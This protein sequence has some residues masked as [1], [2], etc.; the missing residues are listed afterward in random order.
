MAN[1]SISTSGV[2]E[3][4]LGG[5]AVLNINA[6]VGGALEDVD[7][8]RVVLKDNNDA[9]L[10]DETFTGSPI[11]TVATDGG[12][13]T[14]TDPTGTGNYR[15]S[16]AVPNDGTYT[17]TANGLQF[18]LEVTIDEGGDLGTNSV[19]FLV[20]PADVTIS[21]DTA[22]VSAIVKRRTGLLEDV[23]IPGE[24]RASDGLTLPLR[25]GITYE[26][27]A[28]YKNGSTI[29]GG[30]TDYTWFTFSPNVLLTAAATDDDF[31]VF[32]VQTRMQPETITDFINESQDFI[33]AKLSPFYDISGLLTH[34]TVMSLVAARTIG[35]IKEELQEGVALENA[36][37]RS[38]RELIDETT[39][40]VKAICSG[41]VGLIGDDGAAVSRRD[42]AI[43]GGFIHADGDVSARIDMVDRAQKWTG[44]FRDLYPE[45]RPSLIVSTRSR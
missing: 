13:I 9:T 19:T 27:E 34:P 16:Y 2:T 26:I 33:L 5:T 6:K 17:P 7:S 30:G 20:V 11:S 8:V 40:M 29:A 32:R 18:C 43:V 3:V 45:T 22:T 38:G 15:F 28:A 39:M 21:F 25:T 10:S 35:Y 12:A 1:Y 24:N 31:Y 4:P 41:S 14:I 37:Y 42:G 36:K 23:L 44:I